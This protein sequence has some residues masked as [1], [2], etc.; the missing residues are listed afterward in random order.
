MTTLSLAIEQFLHDPIVLG[1]WSLA[2]VSVAVFVLTVWRSI[3]SDPPTFDPRKLPRIVTTLV[4]NRLVPLAVI[5]V[6]AYMVTDETTKA[7]LTLAYGGAWLLA[8]GS[9]AKELIDAVRGTDYG[10]HLPIDGPTDPGG[11]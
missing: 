6:T 5:G 11:G 9:E 3:A 8:I 10:L 1:L 2:V 7:A 4:L